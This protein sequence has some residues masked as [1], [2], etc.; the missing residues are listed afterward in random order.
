MVRSARRGTGEVMAV[1]TRL[2]RHL[3]AIYKLVLKC[4]NIL[5]IDVDIQWWF[6]IRG[7]FVFQRIFGYTLIYF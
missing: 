1:K 3:L 6:S 4:F 7:D 2:E 5:A